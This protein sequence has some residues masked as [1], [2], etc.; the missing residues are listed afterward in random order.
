M[1]KLRPADL[2]IGVSDRLL[3]PGDDLAG[4]PE[5]RELPADLVAAGPAS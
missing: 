1:V 5:R 4:D 3:G 2:A